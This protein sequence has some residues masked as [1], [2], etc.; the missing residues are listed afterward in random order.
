MKMGFFS[1]TFC[2]WHLN[3]GGGGGGG[4][5]PEN[6][7]QMKQTRPLMMDLQITINNMP[8]HQ[9]SSLMNAIP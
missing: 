8:C 2:G 4:S 3:W 7:P 6:M 9:F 1:N 5:A